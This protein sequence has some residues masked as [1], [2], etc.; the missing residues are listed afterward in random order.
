MHFNFFTDIPDFI[1][2]LKG[3]IEDLESKLLQSQANVKSIQKLLAA[4]LNKPLYERKHG[5]RDELLALDEEAKSQRDISF[6]AIAD[7]SEKIK[8]LVA[9]NKSLLCDPAS[10]HSVWHDY[11]S[12]I[13]EIVLDGLVKIASV[14]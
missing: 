12:Y 6:Q 2:Q 3:P 8:A 14:S 4:F 9:E 5:N 1:K 13:D 10:S 11:L 7:M